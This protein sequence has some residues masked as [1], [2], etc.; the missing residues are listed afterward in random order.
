[1]LILSIRINIE[2]ETDT[3]SNPYA[4]GFGEIIRTKPT[5]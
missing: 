1:M 5:W 2:N 4:D 3:V